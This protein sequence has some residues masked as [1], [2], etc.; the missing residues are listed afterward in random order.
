[1]TTAKPD[2]QTTASRTSYWLEEHADPVPRRRA[3]GP[4]DVVVVGG[5]VTGC[6]CALTLARH[7]LRVRLHEARTV[8]GGASGRNGGF[9]LRGGAVAYDVARSEL[10]RERARALWELTERTLDLMA[11]LAG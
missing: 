9:A 5:G 1:M 6:A 2:D 7:G 3:S 11:S 8:A 10:G 4:V